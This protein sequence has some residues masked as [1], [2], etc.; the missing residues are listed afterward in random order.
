QQTHSAD[1]GAVCDI[2][3]R[4][5]VFVVEVEIQK[6]D[7]VT[8]AQTIDIVADS[9]TKDRRQSHDLFGV[10]VF[11]SAHDGQD[12]HQSNRGHRQEED[13]AESGMGFRQKAESGSEISDIGQIK[14]V[15]NHDNGFTQMKLSMNIHFHQLVGRH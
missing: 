4:P 9:S 10:V 5:A 3:S 14:E 7:D 2:K 13:L 6:V 11:H 12:N 8:K 1:N 15:R